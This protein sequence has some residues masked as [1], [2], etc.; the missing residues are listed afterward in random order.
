MRPVTIKLP[1]PLLQA[2]TRVAETLGLS[3][4]EYI[5]RAVE[6]MNRRVTAR[7][8]AERLAA[9]SRRVR[10][11]SVRVNAEFEAIESDPDA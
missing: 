8:R 11:E 1:E 9:V 7:L 6:E 3:R 2:S 4:S 5:R 10:A